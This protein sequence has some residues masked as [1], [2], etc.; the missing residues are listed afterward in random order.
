MKPIPTTYDD[1]LLLF[2]FDLIFKYGDGCVSRVP[3]LLLGAH[4]APIFRG[5]ALAQLPPNKPPLPPLAAC[6][7]GHYSRTHTKAIALRTTRYAVE[8]R[9][10]R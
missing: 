5:R 3:H 2:F 9:E 10:A 8:F 4:Y 7:W 1:L 6:A